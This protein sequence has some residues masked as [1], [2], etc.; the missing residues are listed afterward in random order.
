MLLKSYRTSVGFPIRSK[1][2]HKYVCFIRTVQNIVISTTRYGVGVK[3]LL[4]PQ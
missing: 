1:K 4:T 2:Q 3:R